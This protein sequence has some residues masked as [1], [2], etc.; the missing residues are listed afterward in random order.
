MLTYRYGNFSGHIVSIK[1][2]K[3][4]LH[5]VSHFSGKVLLKLCLAR[6]KTHSIVSSKCANSKLSENQYCANSNTG[7]KVG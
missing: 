7:E 2:I 3:D 1:I 5:Y 4:D 6:Q